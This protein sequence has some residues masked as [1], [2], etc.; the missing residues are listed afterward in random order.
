MKKSPIIAHIKKSVS[1]RLCAIGACVNA[2]SDVGLNLDWL[3]WI[4][5]FGGGRAPVTGDIH[6]APPLI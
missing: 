4:G 5:M 3:F 1:S 6:H 2:S